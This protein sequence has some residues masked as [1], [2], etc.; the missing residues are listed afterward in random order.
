MSES[1]EANELRNQNLVA[2]VFKLGHIG[3][4]VLHLPHGDLDWFQVWHVL[5]EDW[6][7]LT[8]EHDFRPQLAEVVGYLA[9]A[10]LVHQHH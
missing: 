6:I 8:E 5:L 10:L 3:V 9:P 2:A 7:S 1:S 4:R